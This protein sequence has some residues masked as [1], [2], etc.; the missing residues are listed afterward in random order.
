M[1][2][3]LLPVFDR[4]RWPFKVFI[5]WKFFLLLFIFTGLTG[6]LGKIAVLRRTRRR[7]LVVLSALILAVSTGVVLFEQDDVLFS[8]TRVPGLRSDLAGV[9]DPLHGRVMAVG[10]FVNDGRDLYRYAA[11]RYGTLFGLPSIGGYNPLV[12][13]DVYDF[14]M[15]LN[16]PNIYLHVVYPNIRDELNRKCVRYLL[17]NPHTLNGKAALRLD[18]TRVL[19]SDPD[20]VVLENLQAA[21]MIVSTASEA[22]DT[23]AYRGNS[24]VVPL[25]PEPETIGVS[26]CPSANWWYRVDGGAWMR[27]ELHDDRVWCA[28]PGRSHQ[29][30]VRYFDAAFQAGLM[31]FIDLVPLALAILIALGW[32]ERRKVA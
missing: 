23:F 3:S 24:L 2:L 29:L 9:V 13:R 31:L 18:G 4:F 8:H 20:R 22:L 30:E 25:A 7:I 19:L 28:M 26:L 12:G 32:I 15:R 1:L 17:V 6:W 27:P 5:F 11:Y 14:G 10:K 16:I 21:P